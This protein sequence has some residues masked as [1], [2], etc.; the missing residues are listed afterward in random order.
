MI[1]TFCRILG[2]LLVPLTLLAA[3]SNEPP[4]LTLR[5]AQDTAL[6]NHP[7]ISAA[8]LRA[9]AAQQITR[10]AR[11]P[12]F[13]NLSANAVAVGVAND[14]T[15]LSAIGALNNPA[16]FDRNAEG[17]ILSQLITDFGRTLN[18]TRSAQFRAKAESDN[19][20]ATREQILL[21]VASAFYGGLQ[22]QS[23]TRVA[24]ETVSTRQS[25]LDQV[26]EYAKQKLRS[27]LD[28]SFA[29]V[30]L[31][32]GKLL[33]SKAQNDVQA[34]FAQ[35]NI[36]MGS[37]EAKSYRLAEEPLPQQ[38]STNVESFVQQAL[39]DRLDV[40][41]WRD[42]REAALKFARAE[43]D[44]HYPTISAVGSAG[45]V[46][47]RDPALR[48]NYAAGGLILNMPL[49]V[50]GLY[51]A[52]QREAELR[53]K[54]AEEALRDAENNVI[55]D[56]R[57]AWLNTQNAFER[58]QITGRLAQHAALNFELAQT[59][60]KVGTSSIVEFNE[61]QLN[62]ISA[63]INYTNTKFEYLLQQAMLNFQIGAMH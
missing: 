27:E 61:A 17:V 60:Y 46:P 59:R 12:F 62:K 7:Q 54:A 19:A 33:L 6:K 28:V 50:G 32:E 20:Q 57:I 3:D 44:L 15:R 39:R 41:R 5:Q 24:Q 49:Y 38:V 63:D 21:A 9:L 4:V 26:N 35:L 16:I 30:N 18:L 45:V 10:E 58:F 52:R 23:V 34:S 2:A 11:S 51:Q 40:L 13:P 22:A 53:A 43:K 55:R 42:E 37:R 1:Q 47:V 56:V 36:L 31:E 29:N 8:D 14:N 25:F 48:D